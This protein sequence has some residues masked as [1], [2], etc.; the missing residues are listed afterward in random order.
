MTSKLIAAAFLLVAFPAFAA[1]DAEV[2]A[3]LEKAYKVKVIRMNA[4]EVGGKPAFRAVLMHPG[5]DRNG[6]L[7]VSVVTV[8]ATSG[9]LLP[10]YRHLT[11]GLDENTAPSFRPNRQSETAIESRSVWR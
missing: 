8:D 4:V 7:G 6:A 11:S 3:G 1:S 9:A 10:A 2:K 5:G